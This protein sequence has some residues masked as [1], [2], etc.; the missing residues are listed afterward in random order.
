MALAAGALLAGCGGSSQSAN[1]PSTT[2][3]RLVAYARAV[4][5]QAADVPGMTPHSFEGPGQRREGLG[6]FRCGGGGIAGTLETIHSASFLAGF[7]DAPRGNAHRPEAVVSSVQLAPSASV[8][9]EDAERDRVRSVQECVTRYLIVAS[10]QRGPLVND[11]ASLAPLSLALPG[12]GFAFS[13]TERELYKA[14]EPTPSHPSIVERLVR[15]GRLP[16]PSRGTT[17]D[18]LGFARGRVIVTLFDTHSSDIAPRSQERRLLRLLHERASAH[19][20]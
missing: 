6:P 8:A 13:A 1:R 19:K 10:G 5:V 2:D 7:G 18:Y 14:A 16:K 11:R 15:E 17:T 3:A 9:R 20:L 4:N 12:P